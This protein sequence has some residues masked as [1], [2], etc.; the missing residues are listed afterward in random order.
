MGMHEFFLG[1]RHSAIRRTSAK[2]QFHEDDVFTEGFL[3]HIIIAWI[4]SA[5]FDPV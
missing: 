4:A 5:M 3:A 1:N 2:M